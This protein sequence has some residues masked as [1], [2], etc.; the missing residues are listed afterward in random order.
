MCILGY[1]ATVIIP[2]G[3]YFQADTGLVLVYLYIV[4]LF[5][6][7]L[8]S[9]KQ[10]S[11]MD[12]ASMVSGTRFRGDFEERLTNTINQVIAEGNIIYTIYCT[13]SAKN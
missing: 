6:T 2:L 7:M 8:K 4:V 5:F 11:F 12:I 10:I 13:I 3:I 9:K 1:I